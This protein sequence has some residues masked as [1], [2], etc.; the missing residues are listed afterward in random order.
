[1]N[2]N[3]L[4]LETVPRA[5]M[6]ELVTGWLGRRVIE[7]QTFVRD[8]RER[9]ELNDMDDRMLRDIRLTRYDVRVESWAP[10]TSERQPQLTM[11]AVQAED[12]G[13]LR[14]PT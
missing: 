3:A 13:V 1:M 6:R 4:T 14:R 10:M 12:R 5:G 2:M 9:A 8:R 7:V 11:P